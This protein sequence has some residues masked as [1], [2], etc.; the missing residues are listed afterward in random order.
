[1]ATLVVDGRAPELFGRPG[2]FL[3]VVSSQTSGNMPGMIY[4]LE[5]SLTLFN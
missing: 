3:R 2:V 1:M 4:M 5:S